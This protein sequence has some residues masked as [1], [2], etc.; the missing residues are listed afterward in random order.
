M[1]PW[2]LNPVVLCHL[3]R[4][5]AAL[6]AV[7]Q[8]WEDPTDRELAQLTT[9]L[10]NAMWAHSGFVSE[11]REQEHAMAWAGAMAGTLG[12]RIAGLSGDLRRQALA[13]VC[14]EERRVWTRYDPL[15]QALAAELGE[16]SLP[17]GE[18]NRW[19]WERLLPQYPY[20]CGTAELQ[21][22]V[23]QR[24]GAVLSPGVAG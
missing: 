14:A 4:Y 11:N 7:V 6:T 8:A 18:L 19:V 24:L 23:R 22:F 20:G 9:L 15:L 3:Q 5:F 1:T 16:R 2:D 21:D 17:P 10:G 13:L 12:G